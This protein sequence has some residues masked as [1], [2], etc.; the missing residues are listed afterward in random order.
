MSSQ[1]HKDEE[2]HL[3]GT[4]LTIDWLADVLT[5]VGKCEATVNSFSA[6]QIGIGQGFLSKIIQVKLEWNSSNGHQLPTKVVV[7]VSCNCKVQRN[8]SMSLKSQHL[9][10]PSAFSLPC[11]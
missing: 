4:P 1:I 11:T 8:G 2:R 10:K 3:C 9:A 5:S 6:Q 7:K